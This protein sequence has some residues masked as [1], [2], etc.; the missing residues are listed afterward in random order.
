MKL[1]N[2]GWVVIHTAATPGASIDISAASI[3]RYHVNER[4]FSDIG[5]HSVVRKD[6]RIEKGRPEDQMG[7]HVEGFNA[8]SI[9]VC[10]SGNGDIEDFTQAQKLHGVNHVVDILERHGLL[11]TFIRNPMRVIG[12]RET[13][14]L[15]PSIFPG[16][17]TTKTCPGTK[18]DMS[19]FR[20]LCIAEALN[21]T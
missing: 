1:K 14:R 4:G 9:G 10:F 6:G 7:A 2:P 18:V 5:Y 20:K 3:R 11:E 8:K 19:E 12:H 21:R 15:V 16:P 13:G 17:K